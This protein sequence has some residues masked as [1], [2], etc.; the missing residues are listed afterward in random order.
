MKK[1]LLLATFI[2][3]LVM[4]AS[5]QPP[6]Y[7]DLLILF[8]SEKYEKLLSKAEKYTQDKDTK[9]H[10]LPY[11]FMSH[12]LYNMSKDTKYTADPEFKKAFKDAIKYA[13]KCRKMDK[14]ST[15]YLDKREFFSD[16]KND[17]VETIMNELES[18]GHGKCKGLV[19][20]VYK[21]TPNDVGAQY[22]QGAISMIQGD[23]STANDIFKKA[24]TDLD[25]IKS[26]D[27]WKK[28]DFDM[29]RIGLVEAAQ[30][31]VQNRQPEKAKEIMNKGYKWLANDEVFKLKY[32]EIV[33]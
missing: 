7:D 24:G 21:L 11:Y 3:G 14:D 8:A 22:L 32:D 5:A 31:Y 28:E 13:G 16:L 25:A 4:S 19:F 23:R 6:K 17:V 29:L 20:N 33:N 15:V 9:K 10:A 30:A 27:G 2:L 26:V 1:I 18:G 12:A